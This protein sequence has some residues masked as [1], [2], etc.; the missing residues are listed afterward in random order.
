MA[1]GTG[2]ASAAPRQAMSTPPRARPGCLVPGLSES[3]V[4]SSSVTRPTIAK[5]FWTTITFQ[6]ERHLGA[7]VAG[8]GPELLEVG[9]VRHGQAPVE[10]REGVHPHGAVPEP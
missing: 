4:V 8:L 9:G 5:S 7:Q 3:P 10:N 6:R 1:I 2:A